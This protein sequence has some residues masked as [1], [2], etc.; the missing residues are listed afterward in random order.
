MIYKREIWDFLKALTQL[1][2]D[3]K[4]KKLRKKY[5]FTR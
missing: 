3:N 1:N 2:L 4:I 5:K